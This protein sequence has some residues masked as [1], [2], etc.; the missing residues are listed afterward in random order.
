[1]ALSNTGQI[2]TF[3]NNYKG[4]LGLGDE[5]DKNVPTLIPNL[6]DVVQISAGESHSLILSNNGQIYVFGNNDHGQ[7]GLKDNDNRNVPT[8]VMS[9]Y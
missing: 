4:Q 5:I 9:I 7:L 1:L 8:E 3:G 2:Y 6:E